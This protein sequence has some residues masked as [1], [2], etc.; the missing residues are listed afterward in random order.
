MRLSTCLLAATVLLSCGPN[1]DDLDIYGFANGC[2]AVGDEGGFLLRDGEAYAFTAA[3]AA[4]ATPI[5]MRPSDL[6]SYLL[7]DPD[8]GYVV[9]EGES[10][11][12]KETLD[13][14]ITLVEDGYISPAEWVLEGSGR[15]KD[16][17]QFRLKADTE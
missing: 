14:D 1:N 15:K 12:R 16:R 6:G 9:A 2:Y 17:Y 3:A 13:S 11:I 5:F 10:L 7:H 4:S 8:G